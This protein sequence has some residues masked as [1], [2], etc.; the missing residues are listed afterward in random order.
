MADLH[1]LTQDRQAAE[2]LDRWYEMM[3]RI[4]RDRLQMMQAL[5]TGT[6]LRSVGGEGRSISHLQAT[7]AFRYVL[8]GVYVDAGTGNGYKRG[9]PGDLRILDKAYR[10]E[11]GLK[12][13]RKR[14]PWFSP[15]WAI[16]VRVIADEFQRLAG[17]KYVGIVEILENNK[18]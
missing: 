17:D 7:A 2:Y 5:D 16:S 11:H 9:N 13:Q 6:L 15:S 8:Y 14:R 10:R 12:R 1:T 4:W 3:T 18:K